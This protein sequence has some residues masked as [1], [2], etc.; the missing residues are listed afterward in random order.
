[1]NAIVGADGQLGQLAL[2][3]PLQKVS[4]PQVIATYQSPEEARHGTLCESLYLSHNCLRQLRVKIM[5]IAA[6]GLLG[7]GFAVAQSA[8]ETPQACWLE[9]SAATM[10]GAMGGA[11]LRETIVW[12]S[13][14]SSVLLRHAKGDILID[15]GFG[16]NAEAQM[17]EL[18]APGRAFGLQIVSGAKD[19]KP[20]LNLLASVREPPAQVSRIIVTHAHYDHV[21]GATQLAAPIYVSSAEAKWMADQATHPTI[22]PPSLVAAV[23]PRLNIL[24]YDSGEYLGFEASK[25]V[26]GDG[27]VVVVPLPGHTPGSQGLFLKLGERRV[28]LIG[29]AADTLEAAERGLPKSPPIRANTDF[30]PEVADTTTKHI[31]DFHRAHPDIALVPAHDRTAFAAVFGNPSTCISEFR[32]AKGNPLDQQNAE[33]AKEASPVIEVVTLKLKTGVTAAQFEPVDQEMQTNYMAKRSGFLS[34]ESAPGSDNSWLVIVHWRSL[35][36][37]EAS[38]KSFSTAPATAAWMSMIVSDSMGMKRYGR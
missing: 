16:P 21:G 32:S 31:S 15:S 36:D 6:A 35:A 26:Y 10:D 29:D 37:A 2:K 22:T 12:E 38:M 23:K 18:P 3:T 4:A 5:F 28:F 27:T 17:T 9:T 11:G 33:Q 19:R 7:P 24:T 8:T 30:Q 20:I 34:R 14:I 13:T 1:M 25:D